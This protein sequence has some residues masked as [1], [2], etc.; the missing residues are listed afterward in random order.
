[1]HSHTPKS[2]HIVRLKMGVLEVQH[3]AQ[4]LDWALKN[5]GKEGPLYFNCGVIR[6]NHFRSTEIQHRL[7]ETGTTDIF[8]IGEKGKVIELDDMLATFRAVSN[9]PTMKFLNR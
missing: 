7:E 4:L 1:M 3:Y 8:R 5:V 6:H 9:S 2:Y